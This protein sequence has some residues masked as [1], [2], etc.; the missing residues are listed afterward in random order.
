[1]SDK[2][3]TPQ[4]TF[5]RIEKKWKMTPEQFKELLPYL[6]DHLIKDEYGTSTV[7]SEFYDTPDFS[8]IRNSIERPLFKEKLR[9]RSYGVPTEESKVFVEIKRKLNGIG[10]KR[11]IYVPYA[12]AK[13]LLSGKVINSD[14]SQIEKEILEFVKRYNPIPVATIAYERTALYGKD[15]KNLRVTI[16][17]HIRYRTN[18]TSLLNGDFG[19]P[20]LEDYETI[21]MEIK[22]QGGIPL[23]LDEE[24]SKLRIYRAPF[25]KIGTAYTNKIASAN[26]YK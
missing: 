10:Y 22:G 25:S 17:R 9:I 16:D 26:I 20:V 8:L 11:R 12:D 6:A 21:L 19:S 3:V 15:D 2:C 24:F 5:K 1:M 14:N 4:F 23:W 13:K 7:I 18:E